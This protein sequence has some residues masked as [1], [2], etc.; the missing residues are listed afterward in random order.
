MTVPFPVTL[1]LAVKD[2]HRHA[3]FVSGK[4]GLAIATLSLCLLWK[5]VSDGITHSKQVRNLAVRDV[6]A[7]PFDTV[8]IFGRTHRL[9]EHKGEVVLVNIWATWCGPCRNEMPKLERLD[10]GHKQQGF[11]VF[12]LSDESVDVQ[13][14][15]LETGSGDL[16][17]SDS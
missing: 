5:A 2:G 11:T 9:G 10:R 7:P 1:I 15:F 3:F 14:R 8:D 16:S 17:A 12:G 4:I 6:A 13:R